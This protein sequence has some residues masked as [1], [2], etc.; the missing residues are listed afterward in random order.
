MEKRTPLLGREILVKVI[1]TFL[2]IS[3]LGFVH[4][5]GM[6][7]SDEGYILNSAWRMINGQVPYRDFDV[8]YTPVSFLG[9]LT[10]FKLLGAS[11]FSGR[12]LM[13]VISGITFGL[14]FKLIR[15]FSK[16]SAVAILGALVY[17]VWGPGQINFPWPTMFA[18]SFG[19]LT[20][21]FLAKKEVTAMGA[22]LVGAFGIV[23]FLAKQNLGAGLLFTNG[24]F[25]FLLWRKRVSSY[26]IG[27]VSGFLIW[28]LYLFVNGAVGDFVSNL[29]FHTFQKIL[30][31][32][33]ISTPFITAGTNTVATIGKAMFYLLPVAVAVMAIILVFKKKKFWLFPIPLLGITFYVL[34]IR[35][36]TDYNHFVP[37]LSLSG[38]SVAVIIRFA[39]KPIVKFGAIL[40]LL[41]IV[42]LGFYRS[43]WAGYYRWGDPLVSQNVYIPNDRVKVW[44][45]SDYLK[46]VTDLEVFFEEN[47]KKGDKIFVN[48]Y[49]PMVYFVV[50]RQNATRFDYFSDT[51]TSK[52]QQKEMVND[53]QDSQV[54]FIVNNRLNLN[55]KS[56]LSRFFEDK[57]VPVGETGTFVF[58]ERQ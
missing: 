56:V 25:L 20:T 3:Y 32:G 30:V 44:A 54:K 55:R 5:R 57:F 41:V 51:A 38:L 34:G 28:L 45:T 14:F 12:A 40:L 13:L 36:V 29:Y 18:I 49:L 6:I 37:L 26:L 1:L 10:A 8:V 17:L 9:V 33:T 22:I 21:Y 7:F 53:L 23:T 42:G 24:L 35:P 15:R 48:I 11:V 4:F 2:V 52:K 31:E 58:L 47:T 50:N 19:V 27:V 16:S 43:L 39:R 46:R